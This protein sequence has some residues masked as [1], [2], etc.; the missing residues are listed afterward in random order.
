MT[1]GII[2]FAH[3]SRDPLWKAPIEAVATKV[4]ELSSQALATCAYLELTE[5]DIFQATTFLIAKGVNRIR[6]LPAFLGMGKHAREDL[7][8]LIEQL[9]NKHAAIAFELLPAVGESAALTTLLAQLALSPVCSEIKHE[10]DSS[11]S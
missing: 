8:V 2:V 1:Q 7:P 3:G 11:P 6:V 4:R 9:K 5:P 10:G